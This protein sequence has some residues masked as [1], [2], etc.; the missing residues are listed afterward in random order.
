[1]NTSGS[2]RGPGRRRAR[3]A[4]SILKWAGMDY[5]ALKDAALARHHVTKT[6]SSYSL[7][8]M[9]E[10]MLMIMMMLMMMMMMMMIIR[11]IMMMIMMMMVI[12]M[13]MMMMVIMMMM[14][15]MMMIMIMMIMI[16][17]NPSEIRKMDNKDK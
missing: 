14:M 16:M 15:V 8:T 17:M 9:Y 11:M 1:M 6:P 3:V 10:G 5:N 12:M 2:R 4:T 13:M 7:N